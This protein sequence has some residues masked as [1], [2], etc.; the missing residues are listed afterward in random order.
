MRKTGARTAC[1]SN[2]GVHDMIGNAPEWVGDWGDRADG[3]SNWDN[4]FGT[5]RACVGG[6]GGFNF[7][8]GGKVRGGDRNSGLDAGIHRAQRE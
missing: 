7:P 1:V 6:A 8:P 4:S 2:W 5:D 3:C